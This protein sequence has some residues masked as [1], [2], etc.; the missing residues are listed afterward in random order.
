MTNSMINQESFKKLPERV[1]LMLKTLTPA[2]LRALR[3]TLCP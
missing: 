3:Q 2:E 1:Q